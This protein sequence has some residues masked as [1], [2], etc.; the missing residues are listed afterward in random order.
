MKILPTFTTRAFIIATFI[1]T[2]TIC[3]NSLD[4]L[5]G[6]FNQLVSNCIVTFTLLLDLGPFSKL[7]EITGVIHELV[8]VNFN[9]SKVI[10]C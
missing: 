10:K 6:Y 3:I 7:V 9:Y 1:I 4:Y 8:K 5:L 2:I